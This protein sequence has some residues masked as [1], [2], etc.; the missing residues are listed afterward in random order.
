MRR[1][2]NDTKALPALYKNE[3]KVKDLVQ[4]MQDEVASS[5]RLPRAVMQLRSVR[6]SGQPPKAATTATTTSGRSSR[7]TCAAAP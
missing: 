6:N 1:H 4:K 3:A 2:V 7:K 5:T